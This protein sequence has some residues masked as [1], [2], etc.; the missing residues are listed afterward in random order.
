M[1]K[2]KSFFGNW[3]V[4][5]ILGAIV[6]LAVLIGGAAIG[7]GIITKHNR[8]L[9]VPDLTQM[10]VSDAVFEAHQAKMRVEIVDSVYV[11]RLKRGY[12]YK[13]NPAPGSKVKEGRRIAL[14]INAVN[15][16]KVSMPNLVGYSMRQAKAE[17]GTRGLV[18]GKLIYVSD[19]ATNNVLRQLCGNAEVE[20][21]EP[22]E[23]ESVI[24]LVVGLSPEDNVTS[25]PD[26]RGLKVGSAVDAIQENSLNVRKIVYDKTVATYEDSTKAF[27]WRQSPEPSETTLRMGSDVS[28]Y[29]TTDLAKKPVKFQ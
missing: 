3:I 19:M 18:L 12:V 5:N 25:V 21:G 7:L 2:L 23:S 20:P 11:R 22:I 4:R 24:D 28:I 29:L 10:K 26:V 17:L 15:P 13:Q 9:T 27:V 14:T 16:K 8:E 6:V 1:G